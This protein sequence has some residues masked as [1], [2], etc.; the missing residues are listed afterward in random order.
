M[1]SS[2]VTEVSPFLAIA[3]EDG[4]ETMGVVRDHRRQAH[5]NSEN[6]ALPKKS[7]AAI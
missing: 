5:M 6:S 3:E 7:T 2:A 4:R 1:A